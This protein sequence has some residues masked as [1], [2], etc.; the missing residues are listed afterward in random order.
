[1]SLLGSLREMFWYST[2]E[3]LQVKGKR[4]YRHTKVPNLKYEHPY[5]TDTKKIYT[6]ESK[7]EN[8]I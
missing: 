6:K 5:V 7:Q 3:M 4:K 8:V 1:M 2:F